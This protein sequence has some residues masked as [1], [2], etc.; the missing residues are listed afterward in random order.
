[1]AATTTVPP[2]RVISPA[3]QPIRRMLRS[4]CSF[5]KDSSLDRWVRTTSPSRTVTGRRSASSSATRASAIVDLPAPERPVRNTVTPVRGAAD[6][7]TS[8]PETRFSVRGDVAERAPGAVHGDEL[9]HRGGQVAGDDVGERDLLEHV[10]VGLTGGDPDAR[11]SL[12]G[13]GI[14]D[15]LGALAVHLGEEALLDAH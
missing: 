10:P 2:C 15:V 8:V 13:A 12:G 5:E 14:S 3:T 6:M 4:R 11:Q 9:G 7:P 1:M